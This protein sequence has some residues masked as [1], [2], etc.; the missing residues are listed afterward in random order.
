MIKNKLFKITIVGSSVSLR[1]RPNSTDGT[2]KVFGQ[3]LEQTLFNNNLPIVKNFSRSRTI[4]TEVEY[5]LDF[6]I[7]TF[8]E[9]FVINI[10]AVDAPTREI[11]LWYSDYIFKRKSRTA[12]KYF[13]WFHRKIIVRYLRNFLIRLRW[14]RSWVSLSQY[15]KSM[16]NVISQL[17][18]ET[19]AHIIVLGINKGNAELEKKLPRSVRNYQMYNECLATLC[20][21]LGVSFVD[22]SDLTSEIHYPDGVHFNKLGHEVVADRIIDTYE[23]IK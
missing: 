5:N 18:K 16:R 4:I 2:G 6:F 15:E 11:P 17:R 7:R 23:K 13:F 8:P 22:L 3:L 19:N 10:G 1:I 9:L 20:L 14:Y 12:Y 21:D